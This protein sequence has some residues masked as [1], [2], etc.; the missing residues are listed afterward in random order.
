MMGRLFVVFIFVAL[1]AM[2]AGGF[3]VYALIWK[4]LF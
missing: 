2:A 1:I 3:W 4:A